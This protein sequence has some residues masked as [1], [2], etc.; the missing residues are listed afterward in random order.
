M[1]ISGLNLSGVRMSDL[2]PTG[3][4]AYTTPG[5]YTWVAPA[6]VTSVSVVC[7]GAGGGAGTYFGG[8]GG[9][10]ALAY[11]NNVSVIPGQ[12]YTVVVGAGGL[13]GGADS[14]GTTPVPAV[15]SGANSS[16]SNGSTTV[17]AGGGK[18]GQSQVGANNSDGRRGR[19]GGAGGEPLG[20]YDGGWV[21][22][23]GG[24][25]S[26]LIIAGGGGA[27]GYVI[28][29]TLTELYANAPVGSTST[30]AR[31]AGSS[32][33]LAS[34]T[35]GGGGG[36]RRNGGNNV[37][38]LGGGAGG[39]VGILGIGSNGTLGTADTGAGGGGGSGGTTG[40]TTATNTDKSNGGLY[41]GG[42]GSNGGTTY[43]G[44][45]PGDVYFPAGDGAGGAV[46]IIWPGIDRQF[47]ST[48]TTDE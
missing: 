4:Q 40:T 14:Y 36:A 21:G 11:K 1:I 3:Q 16:F 33:G 35:G 10:G 43:S 5:T 26:S 37:N 24:T 47:P 44:Y 46:R 17:I 6:R 31:G 2:P 7:V 29:T 9:G 20:S 19:N 13:G 48:R 12:S 22:G 28:G 42:G 41:G 39:G 34:L 38:D 25:N 15:T 18:F 45:S 30:G 8:G 27:G 32:V 23:S